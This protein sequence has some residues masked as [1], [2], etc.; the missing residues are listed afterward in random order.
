MSVKRNV[1][2]P[3]GNPI[4]HCPFGAWNRRSYAQTW[5]VRRPRPCIWVSRRLSHTDI[6]TTLEQ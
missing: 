2:V 5:L 6:R 4:G 3:L 1:T